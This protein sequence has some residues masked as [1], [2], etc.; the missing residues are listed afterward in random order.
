M[1]RILSF[2]LIA[3]SL[4][5]LGNAQNLPSPPSPTTGNDVVAI[6]FANNAVKPSKP[7]SGSFW[8]V[9]GLSIAMAMADMGMTAHCVSGATCRELNPLFGS[10]PTLVRLVGISLPLLGAEIATSYYLQKHNKNWKRGPVLNIVTHAI[11]V[12]SNLRGF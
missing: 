11:G 8:R 12:A 1:K 10:R 7:L 4:V 5:T 6:E 3:T 2:A 9:N